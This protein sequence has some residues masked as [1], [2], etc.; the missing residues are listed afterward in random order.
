MT[1]WHEDLLDP[2]HATATEHHLTEPVLISDMSWGLVD[3]VV[4]HVRDGE[5]EVVVKAAGSANHHIG[6]EIT[7]HERW[8]GPLLAVGAAPRLL[9][10]DRD[11]RLIITAYLP[12]RLV[13][14]TP[15][16]HE[17]DVHQQAGE[18]LARFHDQHHETDADLEGRATE[19][20]LAWLAGD[21]RIAPDHERQAR[22]VL[23]D[24]PHLPREVT[25]THGDYQ[26]RNWLLDGATVRVID[27]GRAA[28]RPPA[29]DLCRLAVRQWRHRPALEA[30]FLTGYGTDPRTEP[31]W[32]IDLLREA[33]G[34][35]CWAYQV[36]DGAF[37]AEGHRLLAD[38]LARFA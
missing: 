29:T 5:R 34:T 35:A 31:Q 3:T 25:P 10:A 36:G 14:G 16:E 13:E 18:L 9:A 19:R 21:H 28:L 12:G 22:A 6:R 8:T 27:F 23:A 17:T 2:L 11:A 38:A 20:S 24:H 15:A 7:A 30:A 1:S 33:I 26:P 37:E 4:L 32:S